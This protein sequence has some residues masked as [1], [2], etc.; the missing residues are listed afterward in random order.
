MLETTPRA[1]PKRGALLRPFRALQ[2]QVVRAGVELQR[3]PVQAAYRARAVYHSVRN[4][5]ELATGVARRFSSRATWPSA[6]AAM[7][8][9]TGLSARLVPASSKALATKDADTARIKNTP[10]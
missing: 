10:L 2:K 8:A 7:Q 3:L 9:R 5:R 6:W 4:P 1:D